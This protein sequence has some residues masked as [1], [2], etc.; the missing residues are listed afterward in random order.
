MNDAQAA[1]AADGLRHRRGLHGP[2]AFRRIVNDCRFRHLP[3]LET[4]KEDR[5]KQRS[6]SIAGM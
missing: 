6:P 4:P 2:D 3:M 1:A 5:A